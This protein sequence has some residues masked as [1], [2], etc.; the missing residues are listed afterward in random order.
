MSLFRSRNLN[1]AALKPCA[2]CP[3]AG[4]AALAT[5]LVISIFLLAVGFLVAIRGGTSIFSGQFEAQATKAQ[6]LAEA[7]IQDALI[8]LA[9]NASTSAT[10]TLTDTDW[11]VDISITPP[12]TS[13]AVVIATSTVTQGFATVKRAIRADVT[14]DTNGKITTVAKT[15]L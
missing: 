3:A 13:T 7:G 5:I 12:S 4:V 14:M 11:T 1:P 10:Y 9:R 6:F 15:N 2:L 8:R